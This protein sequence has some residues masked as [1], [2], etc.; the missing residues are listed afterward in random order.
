MS[1]RLAEEVSAQVPADDFVALEEKVYRTIEMYKAAREG[2]AAA[3]RDAQR[4]RA[5]L[6]ER[7]EEFENMRREM[8][9]LRKEREEVR[10][11]VE[12]MLKQIDA[13]AAEQAAS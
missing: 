5:Q 3:E 7:E 8:I 6:E 11:R 9:R 12:K 4:L 1:L 13:I 10:G 2:R